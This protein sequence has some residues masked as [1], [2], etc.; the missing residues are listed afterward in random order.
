MMIPPWLFLKEFSENLFARG[1]LWGLAKLPKEKDV[2]LHYN[3][4]M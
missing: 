2:F 4:R 1:I 3:D